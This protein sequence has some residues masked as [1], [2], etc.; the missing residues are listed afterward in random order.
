MSF[1]TRAASRVLAAFAHTGAGARARARF[2][3]GRGPGRRY[4]AGVCTLQKLAGATPNGAGLSCDA[5]LSG[6]SRRGRVP[7][8]AFCSLRSH[9]LK[10]GGLRLWTSEGKQTTSVKHVTLNRIIAATRARERSNP[11]SRHMRHRAVGVI[12]SSRCRDFQPTQVDRWTQPLHAELFPVA[13]L[14]VS[15]PPQE[16]SVQP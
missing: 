8:P 4:S 16:L 15:P 14:Q 5:F 2:R 3:L 11:N 7:W 13:A 9:V 6:T 10:K 12:A 1:P